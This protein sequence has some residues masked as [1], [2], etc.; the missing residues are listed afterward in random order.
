MPRSSRAMATG[1]EPRALNVKGRNVRVTTSSASIVGDHSSIAERSRREIVLKQG[2]CGRAVGGVQKALSIQINGVFDAKT[3]T[4]V[5]RFQRQQGWTP[6][7]KVGRKTREALGLRPFK[8]S[9]IH[10]C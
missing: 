10:P 7:G 2:D 1:S 5:T 8:R 6:T 9:E 4:W 3:K